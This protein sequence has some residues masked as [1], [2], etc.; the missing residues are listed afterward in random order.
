[1]KLKHT[2]KAILKLLSINAR[3]SNKDI[4]K[5]LKISEETVKYQIDKLVRKE[6]LAMFYTHFD[7]KQL[8]YIVHHILIQT[9][10]QEKSVE[11]L[12]KIENIFSINTSYGK[13]DIQILCTTKSLDELDKT[14]KEI[15]KATNSTKLT[16][17]RYRGDYKSF[18]NIIPAINVDVTIPKNK[19]NMAYRLNTE[20]F[21][22]GRH[23]NKFG[24]DDLDRKIIKRI[25]NNPRK[26]YSEIAKECIT[27]HETIRNRIKRM[28]DEG[29]I[30]N[31]GIQHRFHKYNLHTAHL[32]LKTVAEPQ[33]KLKEQLMR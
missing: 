13:Y 27:N 26:P 5:T 3:F 10:E 14:I 15:K 19:K 12:M 16:V 30:Q 21:P 24:L 33:G 8:D 18:T 1:M 22:L 7:Y 4:A 2:Q 17:M 29:F 25:I 31:F 6:D 28:L 11:A 32:L 20:T 23:D 9:D